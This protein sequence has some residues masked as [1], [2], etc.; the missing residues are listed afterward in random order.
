MKDS[1]FMLSKIKMKFFS[2]RAFSIAKAF[3]ISL[4]VLLVVFFY[5]LSYQTIYQIFAQIQASASQPIPSTNPASGESYIGEDGATWTYLNGA[6][7]MAD[8]PSTVCSDLDSDGYWTNTCFATNGDCNDSDAFVHPKAT[9]ICGDTIDNN[10]DGQKEEWCPATTSSC[11]ASDNFLSCFSNTFSFD[12][13]FLSSTLDSLKN[14]LNSLFGKGQP[15]TNPQ[16]STSISSDFSRLTISTKAA[17]NPLSESGAMALKTNSQVGSI[18]LNNPT[19]NL[20]SA[21][22]ALQNNGNVG[23]YGEGKST[24]ILVESYS[25]IQPSVG[26]FSTGDIGTF[27]ISQTNMGGYASGTKIGI[28]SEGK[29]VGIYANGTDNGIT[30][31][32][33]GVT[34]KYGDVIGAVNGSDGLIAWALLDGKGFDGKGYSLFTPFSALTETT[35]VTGNTFTDSL[36]TLNLIGN[37]SQLP[38]DFMLNMIAG[39]LT[40]QD[41][42]ALTGN[43][44]ITGG[45]NVGGNIVLKDGSI[46]T[47]SDIQAGPDELGKVTHL[48]S[49]KISVELGIHSIAFDNNVEVTNDTLVKGKVTADGGIGAF[50]SVFNENGLGNP[51]ASCDSGDFLVS[52]SAFLSDSKQYVGARPS[53]RGA[54]SCEAFSQNSNKTVRVYAYCF[55]PQGGHGPFEIP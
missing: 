46:L 20:S 32:A 11:S 8:D 54:Q 49:G 30:A 19:S 15:D 25:D 45:L 42:L 21:G 43:L 18:I 27:A 10:C 51:Y 16:A 9:E 29:N 12:T 28:F 2:W 24:G 7:Q 14:S 34:P 22:L 17:L 13:S 35:S 33:L 55:D 31:N 50:Y 3:S 23:L 41:S 48:S 39:S 40:V 47:Q 26:V 37:E 36:T 5:N 52:C 1:F 53:K 44:D 6:Y 38:S 4:S